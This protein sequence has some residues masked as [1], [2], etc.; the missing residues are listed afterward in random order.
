MYTPHTH[1]HTHTQVIKTKTFHPQICAHTIIVQTNS[2]SME[3]PLPLHE[4]H[5][6]G[7]SETKRPPGLP[8]AVF[9]DD[10]LRNPAVH[11]FIELATSPVAFSSVDRTNVAPSSGG[12]ATIRGGLFG[13][14][15][16]TL[17]LKRTRVT[18]KRIVVAIFHVP[19]L[20]I[21]DD[22]VLLR[23]HPSAPPLSSVTARS[24]SHGRALL[25]GQGFLSLGARNSHEN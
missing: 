23:P 2:R 15:P 8:M 11:V 6:D 20:I 21:N 22:F 1:T 5:G 17:D 7:I 19:L 24:I 13:R 10:W 14:S 18:L 4:S 12:A 3:M 9:E 25:R 16:R